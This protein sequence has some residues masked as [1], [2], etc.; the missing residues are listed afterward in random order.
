MAV[1]IDYGADEKIIIVE[2]FMDAKAA[3]AE[4]G[5][6]K[7]KLKA[8]VS[9]AWANMM[10]TLWPPIWKKK[11][12]AREW[13]T[14]RSEWRFVSS[15]VCY[16]APPLHTLWLVKIPLLIIIAEV[17]GLYFAPIG[18]LKFIDNDQGVYTTAF[19]ICSFAL[20]LLL[21]SRVNNV[22]TRFNL[23]RSGFGKLG[24]VCVIIVQIMLTC[25]DDE[26]ML[27]D[28]ARW[29]VIYHNAIRKYLEGN[30]K[31]CDDPK[32]YNAY[33]H[34]DE[35]KLMHDTHKMRQMAPLKI[36]QLMAKAA[37]PLEVYIALNSQLEMAQVGSGDCVRI[38]SQSLPYPFTILTTGFIQ[39]WLYLLPLALKNTEL[40]LQVA[41]PASIFTTLLLLGVDAAA[42][43]LENPFK[44]MPLQDLCDS[45]QRD[46]YRAL[47]EHKL[48][49]E[50]AARNAGK[51]PP[52]GAL[53]AARGP[54]GRSIPKAKGTS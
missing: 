32:D 45:T 36:R 20:S 34:E 13:E 27:Q 52:P 47:D 4:E 53:K 48:L 37:P 14:L 10:Y 22:I 3:A 42:V 51:P 40:Q 38:Y 24:N 35:I 19:G 7:M 25:C 33:L 43:H 5:M 17:L 12:L 21:A 50:S 30:L 8:T 18:V 11:T 46:V 54:K 23:G 26:E 39:I 16:I 28:I 15:A 29:C 44:Y 2:D 41:L 31:L 49:L 9:E 6:R 1:P